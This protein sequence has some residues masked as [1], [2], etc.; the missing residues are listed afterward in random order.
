MA[1]FVGI[2]THRE[3]VTLYPF[4]ID[5][6]ELDMHCE[7]LSY[8][9]QLAT[10][11]GCVWEEDDERQDFT[12]Q[13]LDFSLPTIQLP[14]LQHYLLSYRGKGG[15]TVWGDYPFRSRL[16]LLPSGKDCASVADL[17]RSD[18]L[19]RMLKRLLPEGSDGSRYLDEDKA[20]KALKLRSKYD[21]ILMRVGRHSPIV[22]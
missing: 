1:R 18:G 16:E 11:L 2:H 20:T 21:L 13:S 14:A 17:P 10:Y 8:W 3:G 4:K 9:K 22:G 6:E 7:D 12:V 5:K 15:T 19:V